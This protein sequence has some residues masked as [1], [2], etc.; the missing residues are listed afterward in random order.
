MTDLGD[1]EVYVAVDSMQV[2]ENVFLYQW[3][4]EMSALTIVQMQDRKIKGLLMS[5]KMSKTISIAKG[6]T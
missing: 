4:R 1:C 3:Q 6:N 5:V 2:L